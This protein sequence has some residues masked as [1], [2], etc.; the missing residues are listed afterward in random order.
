[1]GNS[2]GDSNGGPV[3][4][5][6]MAAMAARLGVHGD[7]IHV[8]Q[9]SR[10]M[11]I[12]STTLHAQMR[13]GNFPMPHR[14]VGSV[15]VVKLDDYVRWFD[16]GDATRPAPPTTPANSTDAGAEPAE[17]SSAIPPSAPI[18]SSASEDAKRRRCEVTSR[19]QSKVRERMRRKGF[20]V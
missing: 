19:I 5:E 7:F 12:S 2:D 3:T 18:R 4:A 14:K 6:A 17:Q 1:M 8:P 16:E 10:A 20:D 11:G 9:L 13:R 15:L